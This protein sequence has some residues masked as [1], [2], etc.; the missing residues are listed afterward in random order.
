MRDEAYWGPSTAQLAKCAS[1]FA[2]DDG[3]KQAI[4]ESKSEKQIPTA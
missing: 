2:Q 4:V 3:L 1:C